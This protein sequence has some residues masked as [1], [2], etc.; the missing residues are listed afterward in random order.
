MVD[1][2]DRGRDVCRSQELTVVVDAGRAWLTSLVN[3][4]LSVYR[5]RWVARDTHER[6]G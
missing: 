1:S 2:L 3:I 5:F 6:R 4:T